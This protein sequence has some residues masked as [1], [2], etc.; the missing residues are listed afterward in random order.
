MCLLWATS[1][2]FLD[3]K[4]TITVPCDKQDSRRRE[5][6]RSGKKE[7]AQLL[8]LSCFYSDRCVGRVIEADEFREQEFGSISFSFGWYLG[9]NQDLV[10]DGQLL[11]H[12]SPA[13]SPF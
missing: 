2:S 6:N 9:L 3:V 7:A 10:L 12:F 1:H 11:Y 5:H 13:S 4:E 8:G